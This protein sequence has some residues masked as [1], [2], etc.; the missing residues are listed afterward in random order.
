MD[1]A[2]QVYQKLDFV[3]CKLSIAVV[4]RKVVF[5]VILETIK[6]KLY[7]KFAMK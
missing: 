3:T 5:V 7:L 6:Q 1:E 4:V 2:L